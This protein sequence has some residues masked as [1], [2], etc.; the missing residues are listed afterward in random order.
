MFS[1]R[2]KNAPSS[3]P[4]QDLGIMIKIESY[5]FRLQAGPKS[6]VHNGDTLLIAYKCGSAD[7]VRTKIDYVK[8][9]DGMFVFTCERPTNVVVM[10]AESMKTVKRNQD[11]PVTIVSDDRRMGS[12]SFFLSDLF[13]PLNP[14][15][16]IS[17]FSLWNPSSPLHFLV[18]FDSFHSHNSANEH[19]STG[20]AGVATDPYNQNSS[21]GTGE[22]R[23][24]TSGSREE[25]N[26]TEE[27]QKENDPEKEE[28]S[29]D[30][31]K[32]TE[33]PDT[34]CGSTVEDPAAY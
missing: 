9:P 33:E 7:W 22:F 16:P 26:P 10:S 34:S 28:S 30:E 19:S 23:E 17:P 31:P 1:S 6:P 2:D 25:G 12:S 29:W 3:Q 21:F 14:L 8:E 27:E 5:G 11:V 18:D 15:S 32:P 24:G 13:D 20:A 4:S